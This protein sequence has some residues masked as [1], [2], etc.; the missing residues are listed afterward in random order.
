MSGSS[1]SA[2]VARTQT[3]C[4]GGSGS[5]AQVVPQIHRAQLD[6]AR[7][8][9]V[10]AHAL[11]RVLQI[12]GLQIGL[13]RQLLRRRDV[14]HRHLVVEAALLDL[15]RGGHGEDRLAML[16]GDDAAGGE[17]LAVA[18]A[19]DLVDDRHRGIAGAHEIGVQG[20]D[21]AAA[22]RCGR[23]RPAPGRSPGRRRRAASRPAGSGRGT[24]CVPAVRGREWKGAFRSR[25]ACVG[26]P[27][28]C[29]AERRHV[30]SAAAPACQRRGAFDP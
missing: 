13:A 27:D 14:G 19:V 20:M 25:H 3:Y 18:D 4:C 16:D 30:S 11:G 26:T 1:G 23:R 24:G 22:R 6:R 2:P 9:P 7:P 15:E 21:G 29:H 12:G 5:R 17:A 8:L 28:P 10:A